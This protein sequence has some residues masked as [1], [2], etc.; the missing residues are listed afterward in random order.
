M[1][2]A[3]WW[4]SCSQALRTG[5]ARPVATLLTAATRRAT[6]CE[7]TQ[8]REKHKRQTLGCLPNL[9]S[10]NSARKNSAHAVWWLILSC[11]RYVRHLARLLID[12]VADAVCGVCAC[13]PWQDP[14]S[15]PDAIDEPGLQ[16]TPSPGEEFLMS[17]GN[18]MHFTDTND[19]QLDGCTLARSA[20]TCPA[21]APGSA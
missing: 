4:S 21:R 1:T 20:T 7:I 5:T 10:K 8:A 3:M 16:A 18:F 12:A 11:L 13:G 14:S 17:T 9:A 19:L 2:S 6:L 15:W